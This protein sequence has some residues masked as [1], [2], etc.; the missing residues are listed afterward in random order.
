MTGTANQQQAL[1]LHQRITALLEELPPSAGILATRMALLRAT[2]AALARV[3]VAALKKLDRETKLLLQAM[4]R[5]PNALDPAAR[6]ATTTAPTV[7][8]QA[9]PSAPPSGRSSRWRNR[10]HAPIRY[11]YG[12][13]PHGW[14][15]RLHD[16]IESMPD[17]KSS[18]ECLA[19]LNALRRSRAE[20]RA[21]EAEARQCRGQVRYHGADEPPEWYWPDDPA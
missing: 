13:P 19:R 3:E 10:E 4:R 1:A 7:A 8:A 2:D 20:Q 5:S 12:E 16:T 17:S 15:T 14:E 11:P 21:E 6:R 18:A 9:K